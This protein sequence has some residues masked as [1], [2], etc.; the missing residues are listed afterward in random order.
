MVAVRKHCRTTK[1]SS[2][3]RHICQ[4]RSF[5][6]FNCTNL[7]QAG[8]VRDRIRIWLQL[9][10][11]PRRPGRSC[12]ETDKSS[13]SVSGK[14]AVQLAEPCG[15]IWCISSIIVLDCCLD[16]SPTTDTP[17][18]NIISHTL[19]NCS[20]CCTSGLYVLYSCDDY[21]AARRWVVENLS[22][23]KTRAYY[24]SLGIT[25]HENI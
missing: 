7:P 13:G 16:H 19:Q 11:L 14:L 9:K 8:R 2:E 3:R 18:C 10:D 1:C 15:Y 12:Y 22:H 25:L 5:E 23:F 21:L 24:M 6:N 20:G 17:I 4:R